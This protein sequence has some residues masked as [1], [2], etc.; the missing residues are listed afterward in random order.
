M[1]DGVFC[2]FRAQSLAETIEPIGGQNLV[3]FA[4]RRPKVLANVR[5]G[6]TVTVLVDIEDDDWG[7][8]GENDAV[9]FFTFQYNVPYS[10]SDPTRVQLRD[11]RPTWYSDMDITFTS[12]Q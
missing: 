2:P 12:V 8:E 4:K 5:K 3:S 6:S 7:F 1:H 10:A 9:A 11:T